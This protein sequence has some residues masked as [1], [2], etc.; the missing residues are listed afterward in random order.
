[1]IDRPL[2][3]NFQLSFYPPL[4]LDCFFSSRFQTQLEE[5]HPSHFM[6]LLLCFVKNVTRQP[7]VS[8]AWRRA[9]DSISRVRVA[10]H[11]RP[12]P[13]ARSG[14][15]KGPN[16]LASVMNAHRRYATQK[17][18]GGRLLPFS[19]ITH[20]CDSAGIEKD[21]QL[22]AEGWGTHTCV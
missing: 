9:V 8:E 11:Y 15:P 18:R 16:S 13:C 19:Q 12:P 5:L 3:L 6:S 14:F 4:H 17:R 10:C 21:E 2:K 7:L 22:N 20:Q 1:M